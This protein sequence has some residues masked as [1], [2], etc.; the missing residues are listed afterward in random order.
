MKLVYVNELGP[1]FRGDNIYEFIFSDLD[2]VWGED[3]DA[4]PASGKPLPPEINYIKKV[5][6]LRNSDISL[7]L[8][9]NSDFFGVYDAIDGVISLAWERS[10]SDDIL[11]NKRKRL[12]FNYGET[13]ESVNDKLYERDVVLNWEKNLVQDE[14]YES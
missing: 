14:T 5:G 2:D 9:Q 8:I 4:E 10:D 11:I 6:V 13:I 1:N 7:T 3:W 12:V